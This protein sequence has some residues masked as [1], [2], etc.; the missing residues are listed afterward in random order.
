M[1]R[2]FATIEIARPHNMLAAAVAVAGGYFLSGGRAVGDLI[3]PLVFTAIITGFGNLINDFYDADIDRVNKPRRPI[4]SGRLLPG[5][6]LRVYIAGTALATIGMLVFLDPPFLLL[7][8]IWQVLLFTYA[9]TTKR[10]M[11]LGNLVVAAVAGSA[12]AGGAMVTGAYHAVIFPAL[13]AFVYVMGREIVKGAE[14][15]P[16]DRSAGVT[17]L[18]G[19]IGVE[20]AAWLASLL[21][22]VCVFAGPMPGLTRY[23]GRLYLIMMEMVV[24]PTILVAAY[25]VL[26]FQNFRA[27]SRILKIG[28]FLGIVAMGLGHL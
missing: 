24:A 23:F 22:F 15:V 14:D 25:L 19:S 27:A 3:M 18:A 6:V 5:F 1:T 28:M 17:T 11:V 20:K 13:F 4:P 26:R 9:R 10:I 21:L 12:F 2:L 8:L 16:G 7:A